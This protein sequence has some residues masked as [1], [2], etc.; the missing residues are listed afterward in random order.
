MTRIPKTKTVVSYAYTV[1]ANGTPIGTLQGFNPSA[2]RI[3]E[4]IRQIMDEEQDTVEIVPGRSDF[5]LSVDRLELYEKAV[6]EAFG[7]DNDISKIV[8]PIQITEIITSPSTSEK[9]T[10][11]Y[12]RCWIQNWSKAIREGTTT[13]TE[14]VS[15]LPERIVVSRG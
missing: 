4:R 11:S 15:L 14:T 10:I 7:T 8:N 1:T 5:T 13:V 6:F 9:R 2:N 3:L 12:Q